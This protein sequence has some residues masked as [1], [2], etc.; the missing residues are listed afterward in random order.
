MSFELLATNLAT[1][2]LVVYQKNVIGGMLT[3]GVWVTVTILVAVPVAPLLSVTVN[4]M[5]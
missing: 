4:V 5:V 1:N 3:D 2:W